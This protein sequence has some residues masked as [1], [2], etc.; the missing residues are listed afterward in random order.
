M[1]GHEEYDTGRQ[2]KQIWRAALAERASELQ[3]QFGTSSLLEA[4]KIVDSV[5]SP[6]EALE[7]FHQRINE[8][9]EASLSLDM[10]SRALARVV[11]K[12]GSAKDFVGELFAEATSYYA[13]RDL[14]SVIGIPGRIESASQSIELKRRLRDSVVSVVSEGRDPPTEKSEWTQYISDVITSLAG[15]TAEQ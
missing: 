3:E 9:R 7:E 4:A 11:A 5:E 15:G 10:G 13:S 2:F 14:P 12:G 8:S 6:S 1:L